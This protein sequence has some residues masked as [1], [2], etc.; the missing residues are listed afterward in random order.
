M[1][2]CWELRGCD[3]EMRGRCPHATPGDICPAS[4]AYA[5]CHSARH[6]IATAPELVFTPAIDRE[7]AVKEGCRFCEYFLTHGPQVE[8]SKAAENEGQS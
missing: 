2:R 5:S 1:A 3:K 8:N 4:C 6:A 7:K